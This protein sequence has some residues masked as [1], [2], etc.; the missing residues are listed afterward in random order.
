[1]RCNKFLSGVITGVVLGILFA[2]DRGKDTRKQLKRTCC[3]IKDQIDDLVGNKKSEIEK[4]YHQLEDRAEDISDDMRAKLIQLLDN[5][6]SQL[7]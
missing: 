1:M 4:L 5:A 6:K 7:K 2:P 3:D